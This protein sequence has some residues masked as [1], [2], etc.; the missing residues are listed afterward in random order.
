MAIF[1]A[2]PSRVRRHFGL[3]AAVAAAFAVV[4]FGWNLHRH[5]STLPPPTEV[6]AAH[7]ETRI[8]SDGS[9]LELKGDSHLRTRFADGE[10]SIWLLR[11]EAHFHV[12]K[13]AERPFVVY[14]QGA[15]VRA[16]GTAFN[17]RVADQQI[18]VVVTEGTVRVAPPGADASDADFTYALAE[19]QRTVV[20]KPSADQTPPSTPKVQRV[21]PE[22]IPR[23][24]SWR[25]AK[26]EF[27][28]AL[29]GDVVNAFNKRNRTQLVIADHALAL[30]PV[31]LS[32]QSDQLDA[33]VRTLQL[34]FNVRVERSGEHQ[35]VLREGR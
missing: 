13:D 35:I 10:R 4:F 8:L 11:G 23:L 18:E 27:S 25:P 7:Y 30:R 28:G 15:S 19:Y 26:L 1:P 29:L 17:V 32:F 22:D 24:L 14:A 6:I 9:I 12:A 33:F 34:A 31:E 5:R 2:P 3:I 16:V 20:T 21:S